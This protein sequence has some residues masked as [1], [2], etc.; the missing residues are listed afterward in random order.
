MDPPC[1]GDTLHRHYAGDIKAG[2]NMLRARAEAT[3]ARL[4]LGTPEIKI[5]K[6]IVQKDVPPDKASLFFLLKTRFGYRETSA[7]MLSFDSSIDISSLSDLQLD[8]L[9]ERVRSK[10]ASIDEEDKLDAKPH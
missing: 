3:L 10:L 6:R 5:G 9:L 2:A 4:A 8:Q 1:S 7:P